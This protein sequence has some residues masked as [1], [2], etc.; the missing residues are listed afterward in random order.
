MKIERLCSFYASKYHLCLILL[1]YLK[2][3]CNKKIQ[4]ITFM[5]EDI[6][7]EMNELNKKYK[8]N[9]DMNKISFE[10]T[11]NIYE[12]E[13]YKTKDIIFIVQGSLHFMEKANE[14][15]NDLIYKNATVKI[16]NCYEF[17]KRKDIM[18]ELM[19]EADKILY[20]T[21]E[22]VIDL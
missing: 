8:F 6:K 15:I 10:K 20:T 7:R 14:Y 16:I 18:A 22:K 19:S 12:K 5:Q 17:E 2:E 21:G 4:V 9:I 13:P 1:E 3:K 11:D